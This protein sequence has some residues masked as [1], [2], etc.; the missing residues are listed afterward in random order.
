MKRTE[1]QKLG[2]GSRV[3]YRGFEMIVTGVAT[4]LSRGLP[5]VVALA[6]PEQPERT[7]YDRIYARFCR[8][9]QQEALR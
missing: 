6:W 9:P 3:V 7:V 4:E 8:L 2:K 1:E 5:R